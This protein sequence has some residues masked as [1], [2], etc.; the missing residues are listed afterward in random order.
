MLDEYK[1]KGYYLSFL[2]F[3]NTENGKKWSKEL[4]EKTS[5]FKKVFQK[6]IYQKPNHTGDTKKTSRRR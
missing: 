1:L 4:E 3:L 2:D 5:L 6:T